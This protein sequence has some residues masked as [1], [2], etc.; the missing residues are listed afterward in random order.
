MKIITKP[1]LMSLFIF[2]FSMN[3]YAAD[4]N[5]NFGQITYDDV[6]IDFPGITAN[7]GDGFSFSGSFEVTSDIFVSASYSM[8]DLASSIDADTWKIGGGYH[9]P[10]QPATDLVLE[11]M[12]GNS[13]LSS[14]FA[15]IDNDI[16]SIS[17][18]VR[19]S[20]NQELEL[21]GKIGV[22]DYENKSGTD[23]EISVAA[24]YNFQKNIAGL[25][26]LNFG[27][28]VDIMSFGARFYF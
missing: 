3:S 5:Y 8:W 7:D 14:N 12:I 9:M 26:T 17:A 11:A 13:E 23:T 16:W 6:D 10:L 18:G 20:V 15:S 2:S 19:H 4:F 21:G 24:I 1:F 25:V 27:D 28:D 22:V